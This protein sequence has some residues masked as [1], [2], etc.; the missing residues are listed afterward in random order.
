M[1]NVFGE[2]G[3]AVSL[4]RRDGGGARLPDAKT[5]PR[6]LWFGPDAAR[7]VASFPGREDDELV[8]PDDLTSD[9]LYRTWTL[10]RAEAGLDCVRIH[11]LRHSCVI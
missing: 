1:R 3:A 8:F 2:F 7:L 9:R 11:D 5:G 4:N 10:L 6:M